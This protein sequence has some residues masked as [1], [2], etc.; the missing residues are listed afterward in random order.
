MENVH[1][2]LPRDVFLYLLSI[3]TLAASAI[4]AGVLLF[5]YINIYIPDILQSEYQPSAF[6]YKDI[7]RNTL[8]VLIVVFPVYALILRFL[9]KDIAKNPEKRELRIRKWLLYLTLFVAALVIIGDLVAVLRGFLQGELTSRFILK[10]GS[11]LLIAAF[12]FFYYFK[13]LKD[14]EISPALMKIFSRMMIAV[15]GAIV[16]FGFYTAGLPQSQRLVRLD[17]QKISA[18]QTIQNQVIEFWRAKNR[19]PLNLEELKSAT[20]GI[21]IPVDTQTDLPY[22]YLVLGNLKFKLCADFET[23]FNVET[24]DRAISVSAYP[25]PY[26]SGYQYWQHEIGDTCFERTIDSQRLNPPVPKR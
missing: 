15:V 24:K 19:L 26:Y 5:Q 13:Q 2:T 12:V 6:Y 21:T 17:E 8:A 25:D 7:V 11:I 3:V 9:S 1:K 10:S 4:S 18:L 20:L 14:T 22:Q 16:V 23:S